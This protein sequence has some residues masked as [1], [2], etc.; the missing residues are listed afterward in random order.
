VNS[1]PDAVNLNDELKKATE[2]PIQANPDEVF[3]DKEYKNEPEEA[4]VLDEAGAG[5]NTD[6]DDDDDKTD[7]NKLLGVPDGEPRV[8]NYKDTSELLIAAVDSLQT[9]ILTPFL[10]NKLIKRYFSDGDIKALHEVEKRT[11]FK[12]NNA[13][14]L[15]DYDLELLERKKFYEK[16]MLEIPFTDEEY[17]KLESPL[18][19]VVKKRKIKLAPEWALLLATVQVVYPRIADAFFDF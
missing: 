12:H 11:K 15:S 10:K 7:Y 8:M 1:I 4:Q 19:R 2:T 16:K 3:K 5:E 14:E 17:K 13:L 9:T 6:E 18:E